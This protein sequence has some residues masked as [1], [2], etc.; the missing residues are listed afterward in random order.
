MFPIQDKGQ[1][2]LSLI[3]YHLKL[4]TQIKNISHKKN[5]CKT[6]GTFN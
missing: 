2:N 4:E 1:T 3:D 6:N 5:K